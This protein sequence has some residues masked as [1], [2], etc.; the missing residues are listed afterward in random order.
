MSNPELEIRWENA[1]CPMCGRLYQYAVCSFKAKTCGDFDCEWKY[2]HRKKEPN[3]GEVKNP[4]DGC[5][6]KLV[7][8]ALYDEVTCYRTC[9]EWIGGL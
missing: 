8:A 1:N 9:P 5:G 2:Q 6:Q 7:E 3:Q 4:C